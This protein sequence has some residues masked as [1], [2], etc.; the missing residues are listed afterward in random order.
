MFA[1][2]RLWTILASDL[3][4]TLRTENCVVSTR[5]VTLAALAKYLS[6]AACSVAQNG[7]YWCLCVSQRSVI[8]ITQLL[9]P[10]CR[11]LQ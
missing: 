9:N 5:F 2:H 3:P 1:P 7:I 6:Q 8:S 4:K 11:L 10:A